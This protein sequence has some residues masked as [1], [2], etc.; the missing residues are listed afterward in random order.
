MNTKI[1][2]VLVAFLVLPGLAMA[3]QGTVSGTVLD[4]QNGETLPG[5][6]VQIPAEGV[7]AATDANGEFS[8]RV[9]AGDYELQASFVGY[10]EETR[11]ITVTSGSTTQLR[12][13]LQPSEEELQEVVVTGVATGT[14]TRKLGFD[15]SQVSG[16][17]LSEVPA[18]DPANALRGKVAGAQIAQ[19][20]GAPGVSPSIQLRGATSITGNRSPLI[21]VDGVITSGGL[22]DISMQDV[23]SIEVTKGAAASSLYG[24]LAGNGVIQIQTKKGAETGDLD[25]TVRSEVGASQV[26]GDYPTATRHPWT[27]EGMEVQLPDGTT[28]TISGSDAQQQIE[29]LPDGTTILSWPGRSNESFDVTTRDD[30]SEVRLFDNPF[31]STFDNVENAVTSKLNTTNFVSVSGSQEE[32]N[33]KLSYENFRQDGVLDPVDSYTRNTFRFN[34]DYSPEGRLSVSANASYVTSGGPVIEEQ[35]Q[36]DNYFYGLLTADPFIDMTEKNDQGEFAFEPTGY[37]VQGS[38]FSN[39]FY[40]AQN[41]TWETDQERLFGGIGLDFVIL[42]DWTLTAR[43]SIDRTNRRTEFFYP[44]GFQTPDD[45]ALLASGLDQRTDD[46]RQ[47][48]ITELSTTYAG[49]FR[50]VTYTATAKYLYEQREVDDL[51]L[52]GAGF[53]ASGIRSV[54]TTDSENYSIGSFKSEERTENFF[55]NLDLDYQDTYILSGLIRRDGSSLFGEDERWQTYFRGAAAYRL[56]EDFDIPNVSELKLRAAYGSSGNRPPFSAQYETYSATESGLQIENLGNSELRSSTIFETT[57]GIDATFLQRFNLTVNYADSRTEDDYLRVPLAGGVGFNNQF[58]NIGEVESTTWEASLESQ[59]LTGNDGPSLSVG[60]TFSRVRQEITDLGGSPA[61]TRDPADLD[62]DNTDAP[63]LALFRVEEGVPFGAMYG[64]KLLTS[65]DQL[66]IVDGEVL[67]SGGSSPDDFTVNNQGYVI[68]AGTEGTSAEQPVYMVNQEGQ[69][70]VTQIGNTRPDFQVGFRSN[71]TWKGLG[72]YALLDW[73]QG[74]DVYN[75]SKQLLYFNYRH[76]DQQDFAEQGKDIAYSDGSS[77][78]YNQ[79]AASSYFVEDATFVK[80]RELSV[81]Y[82]LGQSLL[83]N[84]LGV[85]AVERIKFSVIGRNLLT[86]TDYSGWDPEVGLRSD[87]N[88]F[89]L[90]EY[91]YPNFRTFTGAVSIQF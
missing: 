43:Q 76:E 44:K 19:G 39:P 80:L 47:D 30:G 59:I 82:T 69:Q 27:V 35:G 14:D 91:A 73:S 88:N 81:S 72:V 9:E 32:F 7:G 33:Y 40:V 12:I 3:Q 15:V 1:L 63:A 21:I 41:R 29:G 16:D 17:E 51:F 89:K 38:N 70:E 75:Y 34:G 20:S 50:D 79:G 8:F 65:L 42:D 25:V 24:S 45:D 78:I 54:G 86:L 61:F 26:A 62:S 56:T 77:N 83:Q 13:Q 68:P 48:L 5:A 49:E 85:T 64:N 57:I 6:S 87:A 74:G 36:D 60:T 84:A 46:Q 53:P 67:N 90:D 71:F 52:E 23:E 28:E 18:T 37:D 11:N 2:P 58:Q 31:P 4:A 66:T 55:L 22:S 10:Q